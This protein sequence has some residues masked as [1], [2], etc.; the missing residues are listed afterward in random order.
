MYIPKHFNVDDEEIL[1]EFIEKN[2]FGVLFSHNRTGP[3]ATH[4][5]F[6]LDPAFVKQVVVV[7]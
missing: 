2:S 6:V 7:L 3:V 5:P 1:F 4:M